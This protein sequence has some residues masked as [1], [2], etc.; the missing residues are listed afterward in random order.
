MRHFICQLFLVEHTLRKPI[1]GGVPVDA[2]ASLYD[3]PTVMID[4]SS[5]W[6][7]SFMQ[8]REDISLNLHILHPSMQTVLRMCRET[9]GPLLLIDCKSIR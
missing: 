8:H 4:Y 1:V 3:T 9:L 5:P 7:D 6:H 2:G